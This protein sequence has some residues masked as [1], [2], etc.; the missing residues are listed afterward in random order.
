MK[1]ARHG[2][3]LVVGLFLFSCSTVP[4]VAPRKPWFRTKSDLFRKAYILEGRTLEQVDPA[5]LLL[6][7]VHEPL[8]DWNNYL[9]SHDMADAP[10]WHGLLMAALA[11]EEAVSGK[12]RDA[13]IHLLALGLKTFYSVT[14]VN[15]LLGRSMIADYKGPRRTWMETRRERPTKYWMRGPTGAW[16]RNGLAKGHLSMACFGCAIPLVLHQKGDIA[17]E[18]ETRKTLLEVLLPAVRRLVQGDFRILDWNGEATE[19]GNLQPQTANGFNML[20]TL[21]MLRSAAAYDVPLQLVYE[22]KIRAWAPRMGWS[23]K[24][25]GR[26]IE[27]L[28]HS[29]FDKPSYSDM[30]AAALAACVL[31]M[32]EQRREYARHIRRGMTGLWTFMQYERNAPFTLCYTALI[33]PEAGQERMAEIYQDLRDFPV[34]KR[35]RRT[36]YVD[37]HRI[38]PLANRPISSHYWKSSPYRRIHGK[39]GE[40][41]AIVYSAQDYLLAYWMGRYFDLIP[42]R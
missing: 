36:R 25:L 26:S 21:S 35:P 2:A 3:W 41:K 40:R 8:S 5:G 27:K 11:F 14:G 1:T 10:A 28:G 13:D 9:K 17:L 6:Y 4:E 30:Q 39:V 33:R 34:E 23:L 31:L 12:D 32:Q 29:R 24:V 7:C 20:L 19:Y 16:W 38:Q 18:E 15:G 37:T 22:E 42:E